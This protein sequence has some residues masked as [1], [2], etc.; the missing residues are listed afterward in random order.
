MSGEEGHDPPV[1]T[2]ET[3]VPVTVPV[4]TP[5]PALQ[6][7]SRIGTARNN[8]TAMGP[9]QCGVYTETYLLT[10]GP[11]REGLLDTGTFQGLGG[12]VFRASRASEATAG[13]AWI[14]DR[15]KEWKDYLLTEEDEEDEVEQ[16]LGVLEKAQGMFTRDLG[17]VIRAIPD[18]VVCAIRAERD[19]QQ[20]LGQDA[21]QQAPGDQ[22]NPPREA[23]AGPVPGQRPPGPDP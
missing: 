2:A 12:Q 16:R 11:R 1:S 22:A 6:Y 3:I 10:Q 14:T 23:L 19:A 18:M 13:Q 7:L 9:F 17:E 15:T 20:A 5:P 4:S 8:A 21:Q